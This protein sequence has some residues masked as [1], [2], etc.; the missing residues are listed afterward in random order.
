MSAMYLGA[1]VVRGEPMTRG[2]YCKLRS[3]TLPNDE[4]GD[5]AGY[6]VEYTDGGLANVKGF[7]GFV[8]WAPKEVFERSYR[9]T[10]GLTFGLA[11]EALQLGHKVARK[12]WNGSGQWIALGSEVHDLEAAN[13]WN[14]HTRKFAFE[15]RGVATVL[16][17]FILKTA[18]GKILMGWSPSQSDC[19]ADDWTILE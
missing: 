14:E 7:A 2:A 3:W 15:N 12:G 1:K 5:D 17:Y 4:D 18:Q 19:L 6:L 8:S 11:L 9:T 13:F 10:D 16:P